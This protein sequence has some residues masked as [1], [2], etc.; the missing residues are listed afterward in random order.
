M[1]EKLQVIVSGKLAMPLVGVINGVDQLEH[2]RDQKNYLIGGHQVTAI[3][4]KCVSYKPPN[5]K[6]EE[7]VW[8]YQ[9]D[10]VKGW[11]LVNHFQMVQP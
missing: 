5:S 8:A 10:G 4:K 9:I 6:V 1:S 11:F 7:L 2:C 3:D